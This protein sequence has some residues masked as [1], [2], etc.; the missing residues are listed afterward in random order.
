MTPAVQAHPHV[1]I[2]PQAVMTMNNHFISQINVEWDF[3]AMSSSLFLE[4][5]G[6][7]TTQIWSLVFPDNQLLADGRQTPR[8]DYYTDVEIDGNPVGNLV[9]ANFRANFVDGQ[10]RCTFTLYINQNVNKTLKVWFDDPTI[11][12]AF[13]IEPGNFSV[14]GQPANNVLQKQTEQD[15]DKILVTVGD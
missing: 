8:L 5:C 4:S 13:D 7:D 15:T 14:A 11:Y 6:A 9:P 3:D 10:L 12:N 2:T 1:F